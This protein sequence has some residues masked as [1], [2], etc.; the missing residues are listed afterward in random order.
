MLLLFVDAWLKII[1]L[2]EVLEK[3]HCSPKNMQPTT[4]SS[5]KGTL[6]G[7]KKNEGTFC[8]QTKAKLVELDSDSMSNA[9]PT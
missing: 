9:F 4:C 8:G 3:H 5:H 7:Q 6:T 1:Y 2:L